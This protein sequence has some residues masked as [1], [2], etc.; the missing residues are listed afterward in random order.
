MWTFGLGY[1]LK[2]EWEVAGLIMLGLMKVGEYLV[3]EGV[4]IA[5]EV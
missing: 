3:F 4:V 5:A 1:N 2:K